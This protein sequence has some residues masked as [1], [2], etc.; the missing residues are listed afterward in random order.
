MN[1]AVTYL[2]YEI[3]S[4]LIKSALVCSKAKFVLLMVQ[5]LY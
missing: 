3:K 1:A 4:G 5:L 2:R